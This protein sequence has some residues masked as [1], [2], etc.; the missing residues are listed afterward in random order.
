MKKYL[1]II[2]PVFILSIIIN[3][4]IFSKSKN[5][6]IGDREYREAFNKY[7]KI[8]AIDIPEEMNFCNETVPIQR[9]DVRESYD[10]EMLVNTY[11]QSQTLMFF[12]RA[13]RWFPII[14]NILKKNNLPDDLKYIAIIESGFMNVKSPA[15]AAGFWQFMKPTAKNYGLEISEEV[16]ERYNLEKSTEA[17]CKYFQDAYKL[18][19]NWTLAAA[20]YNSGM[21]V[22][23]KELQNQ[24]VTSYYDLFL[25]EETG[26]YVYRILAVKILLNNPRSYGFYF[27]KKDLY[28]VIPTYSVNIDSSISDLALFSKH[29]NISYKLLKDFNPWVIG[30]TLTN[31]DKKIYKFIIPK[32]DSLDYNVLLKDSAEEFLLLDDSSK[33]TK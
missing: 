5:D 26:R 8:F 4:F 18:Y 32:V 29:F 25:N 28:P 15:G 7:Y 2:V 30:Y 13:N 6:G 3:L 17:V 16:D 31:K 27:R 1:I 20:S 23:T 10:R 9:Y 19:K 11:W 21:G 14:E 24:K 33:Q 22:L 12:K